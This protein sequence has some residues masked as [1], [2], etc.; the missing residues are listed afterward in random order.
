MQPLLCALLTTS[1]SPWLGGASLV[2]RAPVPTSVG[3]EARLEAGAVLVRAFCCRFVLRTSLRLAT[4]RRFRGL[5]CTR[6]AMRVSKEKRQRGS[7]LPGGDVGICTA[8]SSIPE[9]RPKGR[10]CVEAHLS[11]YHISCRL[12]DRPQKSFFSSL[13]CCHAGRQIDEDLEKLEMA[14]E[15]HVGALP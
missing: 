10:H 5:R 11:E 13:L 1:S 4:L 14:A 9:V 15:W 12:I 8:A 3:T 6:K 2:M 7:V